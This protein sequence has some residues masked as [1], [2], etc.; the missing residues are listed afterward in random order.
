MEFL[1]AF[2]IVFSCIMTGF[3]IGR[4]LERRNKK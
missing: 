1:Y 3:V 2:I 4:G